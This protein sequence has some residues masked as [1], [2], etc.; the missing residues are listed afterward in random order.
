M[1]HPWLWHQ[2]IIPIDNQPVLTIMVTYIPPNWAPSSSE[3]LRKLTDQ[4]INFMFEQF[5]KFYPKK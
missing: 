1:N 4:E 5:V 3:I 2:V